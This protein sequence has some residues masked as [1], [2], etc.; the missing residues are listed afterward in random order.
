[1]IETNVPVS[2]R[3][4]QTFHEFVFTTAGRGLVPLPL[5]VLL[6]GTMGSGGTA[7]PGVPQ[8]MFDAVRS[9]T[10]FER[11]SELALLVRKAFE[12]ARLK[13][14]SPEIWAVG[15]A[16]PDGASVA[17][18]QTLTVTAAD[19]AAGDVILRIAGR[20]LRVGVSAGDAQNDIAAAIKAAID[21]RAAELPVT[22]ARTDNV[23][24]ATHVTTGVNGNDVAYEVVETPTGVTVASAQSVAGTGTT[25]LTTVLPDLFDRDYDALCVANHSADDVTDLV[26]HVQEGWGF[27]QKRYRFAFFGVTASL[28]T[29]TTRATA[30]NEKGVVPIGCE[31]SP[32]L[33]GELAT[34]AAV[35][36]FARSRPN[37]NMDGDELPLFPPAASSA[38]SNPEVEAALAGGV[39]PLTPTPDG[40]RVR[41]ERM[42]T[43][44]TTEDGAPFEELRD[45]QI[46]RTSAERARQID[47]RYRTG[48]R[49][50]LITE[51]VIDRIRDS[52]IAVDRAL[53]AQRILH[54]VD[55]FLSSYQVHEAE[56]PSGRVLV[57]STYA[58]VRPLHQ[59]AFVHTHQSL[60]L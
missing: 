25:D 53:E 32:S 47:I 10:L 16:A 36:Y 30:A 29:A 11:G 50:E 27:S 38:W 42:V 20:T 5:R 40:R 43:S 21:G 59:V 54:G 23:V 51:E 35:A 33:P 41:I 39:T 9:D 22:A 45:I 48:F 3:R 52:V 44:K 14:A 56:V 49:Q 34:A 26:D 7:T 6:I 46:A 24:T 1:M 55:Q 17:A 13:G 12:T 2:L 19:A 58:V 4:P 18:A 37:H 15:L 28:A 60:I 8:Q 31:G 57:A